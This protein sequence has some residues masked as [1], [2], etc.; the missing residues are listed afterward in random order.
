MVNSSQEESYNNLK[1]KYG[2]ETS[3]ESDSIS[4]KK[5]NDTEEQSC[6]TDCEYTSEEGDSC[7]LLSDGELLTE[8]SDS[9]IQE[10]DYF[11]STSEEETEQSEVAWVDSED[12]ADLREELE[13]EAAWLHT[14]GLP[15]KIQRITKKISF[16][17][18]KHV[19]TAKC[20]VKLFRVFP[21]VKVLVDTFN[22]IYFIKNFDDFKTFKIDYFKI[23]DLCY[24]NNMILLS[25]NTSSFI[26]HISLDGKVTDIKK[27]TG[28]IKKLISDE[29]LYVLGDKLYGFNKNLSL[30]SEFNCS[31][32]DMCVIA[33][34]VVCLEESGDIYV[35]DKELDFKKKL[36]F[37]FKFQFKSLH[38]NLDKV[39]IGTDTGIIIL[40]SK[41]QEIKTYSTLK[42]PISAFT[43]ND[44]FVIHGSQ[45]N[46]SLRIMNSDFSYFEKFPFSK[47]RISPISTMAFE[48][49]T[50][51]FSNSRFISSLKLKYTQN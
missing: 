14:E 48:D 42:E 2:L 5:E 13:D 43:F 50:V 11:G 21:E 35:F 33:D 12:D 9:D 32:I 41:F 27:G 20:K 3:S 4:D 28:N 26:K 8:E 6:T 18:T 45:Y 23:T 31:F 40:D 10:E 7:I 22:L 46:N 30:I 24:F 44:S 16:K 1:S 25:S 34:F 37:S 36:S 47:I 29:H 17:Y 38:S 49:E 51:Y 15:K 39:F 19:F